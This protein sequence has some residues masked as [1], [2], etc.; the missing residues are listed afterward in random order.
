MTYLKSND[1][2]SKAI[3]S[4]FSVGNDFYQDKKFTG[5]RAYSHDHN[6][7]HMFNVSRTLALK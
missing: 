3:I 4:S 1:V 2:K 7:E 5:M 6:E